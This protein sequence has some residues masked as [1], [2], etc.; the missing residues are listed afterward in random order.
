MK[1]MSNMKKDL[2]KGWKMV[3]LGDKIKSISITGK[4]LKQIEYLENGKLPVVDQG[5]SLIGGFTNIE[6]LKEVQ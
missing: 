2:P 5:Q 1:R 3:K 4:K 6:E